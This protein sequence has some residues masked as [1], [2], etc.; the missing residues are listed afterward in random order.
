MIAKTVVFEELSDAL[1]FVHILDYDYTVGNRYVIEF[2]DDT[3]CYELT[4]YVKEE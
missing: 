1:D 3:S 2:N 4:Y